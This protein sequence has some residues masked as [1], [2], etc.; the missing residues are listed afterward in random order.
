MYNHSK[1]CLPPVFHAKSVKTLRPE[2]ISMLHCNRYDI[3]CHQVQDRMTYL[4]FYIAEAIL[5]QENTTCGMVLWISLVTLLLLLNSVNQV[6]KSNLNHEY[7]M[8]SL[9]FPQSVYKLCSI[10]SETLM[11][12]VRVPGDA[13]LF[14]SMFFCFCSFYILP[15]V[16]SK[17]CSALQCSLCI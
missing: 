1:A 9:L 15:V 4:T 5:D 7:L 6:P 3:L 8:S 17:T 16:L 11:L 2:S 14:S 13:G 10:E 12:P